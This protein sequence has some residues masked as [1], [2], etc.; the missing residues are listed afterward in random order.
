MDQT[1]QQYLYNL[2]TCLSFLGSSHVQFL[3]IY[4][5]SIMFGKFSP[6]ECFFSL[7]KIISSLVIIHSSYL[8]YSYNVVLNT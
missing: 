3:F 2:D 6:P 7:L 1:L 5:F 8:T 4:T